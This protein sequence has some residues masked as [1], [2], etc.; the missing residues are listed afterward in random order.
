MSRVFKTITDLATIP[1]P[2]ATPTYQPVPQAELWERVIDNVRSFGYDIVRETHQMHRKNPWFISKV[3]LR[4]P[5]ALR[6]SEEIGWEI[7]VI[8]SYDGSKAVRLLFGGNVFACTNGLIVADH[9][10]RTKHTSGV[11]NRLPAMLTQTINRFEVEVN[12]AAYFYDRIKE[13]TF[14]RAN[15]S[16]FAVRLGQQGLLPRAKVVDLVEESM[17]PSFGY[18]TRERPVL[19]NVH[20]AYTHLAKEWNPVEAPR[21]IMGMER[22]MRDH[23]ALV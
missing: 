13:V 16:D 12:K 7:G 21:K 4:N 15:L 19:W 17:T 6:N 22:T 2:V 5:N 11:W 1:V 8:N 3:S 23:Y 20:N 10:L 18:D 9:I 14:N